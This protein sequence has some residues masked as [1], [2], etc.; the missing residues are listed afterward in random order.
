MA[1]AGDRPGP[2]DDVPQV[3]TVAVCQVQID[4]DDP[5]AT[6]A[7]AEDALR[8]A[9]ATGA[10]LV[11]LPELLLSGYL[12][13]DPAEARSRAEVVEDGPTLALLRSVDAPAGTVVVAGLC[14]L[15][16]DGRLYNSAVLVQDGRVLAVH[17][18][19]H[20]WGTE[21]LLFTPGDAVSPVVA[22]VLGRI[23]VALCYEIE[24][25]EWVRDMALRGADLV[26]APSNWPAAQ[27]FSEVHVVTEVVQAR[28]AAASSGL[29]VAVA[30]R[31][32]TER[33]TDWVGGSLV[34]DPGGVLLTPA[35][36]G[37]PAVLTAEVD[38]ARSRD[39]RRG[40]YNDLLRDRRVDLY[41]PELR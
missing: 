29:Y 27:P 41:P 12:M 33:G 6:H 15:G 14:E 2:T 13:A 3:W 30:D 35:A 24:F 25:P 20:L 39:K 1:D 16:G 36:L 38:P 5:V 11:V 21:S 10:R 26:A 34:A 32:G 8:R 9:L 19:T 4:T 23:G 22:T 40:P 18:K 17:R 31:C 28:A 37:G 7:A